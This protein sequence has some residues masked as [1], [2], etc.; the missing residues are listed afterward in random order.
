MMLWNSR[1]SPRQEGKG[2]STN[3]QEVLE[4]KGQPERQYVTEPQYKHWTPKA[5]MS[6]PGLQYLCQGV[7]VSQR[8]KKV[9][10]L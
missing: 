7:I 4:N 9:S 10:H 1:I 3:L 6:L 5:Q 8:M 2:I